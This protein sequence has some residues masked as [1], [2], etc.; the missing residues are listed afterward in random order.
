[1]TVKELMEK[2]AQFDENTEVYVTDMFG[3]WDK[4]T[5]IEFQSTEDWEIEKNRIV[6]EAI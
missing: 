6:L 4:C 3:Y 2:L 5:N 1:M